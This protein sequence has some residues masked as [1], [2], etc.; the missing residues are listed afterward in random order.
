[1]SGGIV[2]VRIDDLWNYNVSVRT[3]DPDLDAVLTYNDGDLKVK[4]AARL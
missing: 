3:C 1:V 2:Y 4:Q